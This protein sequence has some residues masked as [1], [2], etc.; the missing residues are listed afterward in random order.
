MYLE[1]LT[2]LFSLHPVFMIFHLDDWHLRKFLQMVI[3]WLL[4]LR[5]YRLFPLLSASK[6]CCLSSVFLYFIMVEDRN[7]DLC[8]LDARNFSHMN[9][10]EPIT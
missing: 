4:S 5:I 1:Y 9:L 3:L 7:V 6:K 10:Y 8:Y 2:N